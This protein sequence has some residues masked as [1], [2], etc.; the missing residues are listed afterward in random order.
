MSAIAYPKE[1][2]V[3]SA[4]STAR[5]TISILTYTAVEAS[6]RC[7]HAVLQNSSNFRLILT[8]NG[9]TEIA[10]FFLE[11]AA[12]H[13]N[14]VVI[15]N[16]KNEGFIVPN[17]AAFES[18]DTEFFVTLNDDTIVPPGWLEK[19]SQPFEAD[20]L[21]A[22]TG[23]QGTCCRLDS[24]CQGVPGHIPEYI[25]FSCAMCK[26]AILRKLGLFDP[27]L[28]WAYYEDVDTAFRIREAGYKLKLVP[29]RIV[30]LR[31]A[32][33]SKM[34]EIR[35]YQYLNGQFIRRRWEPYLRTRKFNYVT[36]IRRAAAWGDVLL[37][38]PIIRALKE[39]NPQSPI[40][41]ETKCAD[42]FRYHPHVEKA[43]AT[44]A[45]PT[46]A[47]VI[48]LNGA[49]ENR[50]NTHLLAAYAEAAALD[51]YS[52]QLD[53]PVSPHDEAKADQLVGTSR[54]LVAV[55]VGPTTWSGKNW[56]QENWLRLIDRI[57]EPVVL[58]G[59]KG[60][61]LM[62]EYD[63]RGLTSIHSLAAVLRRCRMLITVD[64]FPL[65]VAQAV[66]AP[67]V[68]LFGITSPEY[69]LTDGSPARAV[70]ADPQI[71]STGL[72]HRVSGQTMVVDHHNCMASISVDAVH[73][74]YSELSA[75]I[76]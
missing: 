66:G 54:R 20:P 76:P 73:K 30:H 61:P 29:F 12:R 47:H 8:A 65:H 48:D 4:Q 26:T 13:S 34:P 37:T 28:T 22:I 50:P 31:A 51:A 2:L 43:G 6:K 57:E 27:N 44:L 69:I 72:R 21:V 67:V 5:Y 9:N 49:S 52:C 7:I 55:H 70:C 63:L 64:S 40:W 10:K 32:T 36:V 41:V 35:R 23:P 15:E 60:M 25:E 24:R 16:Q 42:L 68:G 1:E 53:L 59:H 45:L 75:T 74:A 18:C 58:V 14:V 46:D 56:P 11:I 3:G 62:G 19:L 17:L 33:S 71:P 38:T 39:R